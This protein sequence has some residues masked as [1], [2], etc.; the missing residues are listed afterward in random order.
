MNNNI[1]ALFNEVGKFSKK[2]LAPFLLI[3]AIWAV[4]YP[5]LQH[6]PRSDEWCCLLDIVDCKRFSEVA[7]NLYSEMRTTTMFLHTDML[8]F[9]PINNISVGVKRILFEG[10]LACYQ[11][12]SILL[13]CL[14]VCLMFYL[15]HRILNFFVKERSCF[16]S[17]RHLKIDLLG[18]LP[19]LLSLFFALN[20]AVMEMV[21][22]AN[23]A[24]YLLF[25]LF[26]LSA[27]T[28]LF[29]A[30]AGEKLSMRKQFILF[31]GAWFFALLLAFTYE[32]GQFVALLLGIAAGIWSYRKNNGVKKS[33]F[34]F[35][36]FFLIAIIYQ[37]A[38]ILDLHSHPVLKGGAAPF[39]AIVSGIFSV[40]TIHNFSRL[41]KFTIFQ[42]FFP[43]YA[44]IYYNN[45]VRLN[46][47]EYFSTN[48]RVFGGLSIYSFSIFAA[49]LAFAGLGLRKLLLKR[50]KIPLL[51]LFVLT[52]ALILYWLLIILGRMNIRIDDPYIL[53]AQSYYSYFSLAVFILISFILWIALVFYSSPRF[54]TAIKYLILFLCVGL[55]PISIYSGIRIYKLNKYV[56]DNYYIDTRLCV[57]KINDFIAKHKREKGF[58][59]A[60]D[61]NS[62]KGMIYPYG[63][64]ITTLYFRKYEDN[65]NPKYVLGFGDG[66]LIC[67]TIEEYR[68]LNPHAVRQ[69]SPTYIRSALLGPDSYCGIFY[70]DGYYYGYLYMH[71]YARIYPK[72]VVGLTEGEVVESIGPIYKESQS[73]GEK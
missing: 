57:N 34:Y 50:D 73:I 55:G 21:I 35:F 25:I 38:N 52:G 49:W 2:I 29:M 71:Q 32:M 63:V 59:I 47:F 12:T 66:D 7:A 20:F 14:I 8:L 1:K 58:S 18:L 39:N 26:F 24:G 31:L 64:P 70:Y 72:Y 37:S 46:I 28:L 33:L 62:T 54:N 67:Q 22:W 5:S 11:A 42:P 53:S 17:L 23:I 9:R 27:I 48:Y 36:V 4:Y 44:I 51:L 6:M 40:K 3:A 68:A 19:F 56:A 60:I 43:W 61:L 30:M 65:L 15:M 16:L 13:H 69:I 45:A 10:N 41:I